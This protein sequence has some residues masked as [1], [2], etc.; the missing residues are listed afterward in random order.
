MLT[1]IIVPAHNEEEN[2]PLMIESLIQ[3]LDAEGIER[4][5]LIIDD[6]SIDNTRQVAEKLSKEFD[7]V[8][9]V[10]RSPPKGFGRALKDGLLAAKGD[11]IIPVMA[12]RSEDPIDVVGL[13]KQVEAGYDIAFGSRFMKDSR[14]I[15]YPK[16]KL[17]ANRA[18]NTLLRILF[19]IKQNDL[20]NAFKAYRKKVLLEIDLDS[21]KSNYFDIN[22]EL[23]LKSKALGF[24]VSE[25]PVAWLGRTKG[26]SKL[27]LLEMGP[28]YLKRM[29]DVFVWRIKRTFRGSNNKS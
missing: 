1:S 14:L 7:G 28:V 16:T 12:D 11:I 26:Q 8:K 17:F 6:N 15:D 5:I 9:V 4:E 22:I 23:S 19:L 24:S 13:I 21:L 20:T 18:F 27:K 3:T 25:I 10:F 2:L 29:I